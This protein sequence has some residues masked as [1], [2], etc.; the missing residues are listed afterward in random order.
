[1]HR[2]QFLAGV[3]ALMPVTPVLAQP[4]IGGAART[5]IHVPQANLTSLDPVWTTAIVTRNAAGMIFE[6][7]Y[8]RDETLAPKP[9]M[10]EADQVEDNGLRW[11]MR[12]R[13]GLLFHDGTPV[14]ARDCVASLKRWMRRDPIGQT[15]AARLDA[16]EAADDRTLVWRL[17][18]PFASLPY[19]LAKTQPSPVIMPE[20][21]AETDPFKQVPEVIGSGPFRY[22]PDEYVSGHRAVFARFERY[23]PRDEP[24]SFS[25]G[26]YR[27]LV[28]RVEWRI[29]PDAATA[30]NALVNGEVDWLDSPLP[31]LLP[32]LAKSSG[33]VV[34]PI[35]IYGTLGGLRPNQL[36]GATA[37]PGV[38]RAMLAAIDQVDVMTAVMGGDPKLFRA[39]VGYFMPGT[40][41]ANEAGM[42]RVRHRPDTAAI[43]AMLKDAG[44]AGERVVLLHPTDQIYYDAMSHVVGAALR[45]VGINL[46]EQTVDWGTVVERRTSKADLDKGGWSL[47]PAGYPAAEYRDPLFASNIR[48]NGQDAWFGWPTDPKLEAMRDA[49]MESTDPAERKRLDAG[50]QL[51]AF[52]TVPFI[53]LGQYLPPAAWRGNLSGLLKGATP[54]FW[55]VAKG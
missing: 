34:A 32:M 36:H 14:L 13:P 12:L 23:H 15:I 30:A 39:P 53:P 31:D 22:V 16:L 25:A 41:S 1:M 44:Y 46:D 52:D 21:L 9:Q 10:V 4:A 47:F 27:V 38:R 20:R 48:G 24:V 5:L 8:G 29:I 45:D 2:R 54:V 40:P 7:L 50:I 51:Q 17:R 37:N 55:N 19:A 42:D 43:K 35:D 26:G 28:E 18:K 6:T 49:W 3:A 33:V 11:T